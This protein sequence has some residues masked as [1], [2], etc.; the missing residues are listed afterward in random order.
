MKTV[1]LLG[2]G[3]TLAHAQALGAE[4]KY[5]P[6]LDANLFERASLLDVEG[7]ADVR[8]FVK[9]RFGFRIEDNG[10]SA[11]YV[12]SL[13]HQ[14]AM[15]EPCDSSDAERILFK[16]RH[17]YL[18]VIAECTNKLSGKAEHGLRELLERLLEDVGRENLSIV[19]F[20]YDLIVEKIL[21]AISETLNSPDQLLSLRSSYHGV[22]FKE[23]FPAGG[24]EEFYPCEHSEV[25][26][27]LK[28]HGS[29]NWFLAYKDADD[30]R[31]VNPLEP[32]EVWCCADKKIRTDYDNLD[33][34]GPGTTANNPTFRLRP[35]IVPPVFDKTKYWANI[36]APIWTAFGRVVSEADRLV[37]CG[38]S[39]PDADVKAQCV[40]AGALATNQ[41]LKRLDVIDP[42]PT[43]CNR[44]VQKTC[45]HALNYYDSIGSFLTRSVGS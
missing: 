19:T 29:L 17:L 22:D 30:Y 39:L 11:E 24:T 32:V 1:L 41:R 8:D 21:A 37:I 23:I 33:Y 40:I 10:G 28:P 12:F 35:L 13:V 27:V 5:D 4:S 16:L 7:F 45:I 25:I 2:A 44:F 14:L 31:R 36:L 26:Q 43:V 38:Y 9:T 3:S 15:D 42:N 6:P 18:S 20:N 34:Y